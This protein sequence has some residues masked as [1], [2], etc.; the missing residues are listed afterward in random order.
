MIT[1]R[2]AP[3]YHPSLMTPPPPIPTFFVLDFETSGPFE[4]PLPVEVGVARL[5]P[6][7]NVSTVVNSFV[8]LPEGETLS[9]FTM[10]ITG[11]RPNDLVGA[12]DLATALAPLDE[13]LRGIS[14][15]M[16]AAHHAPFDAPIF[17]RNIRCCPRAHATPF[18]CTVL[19]GRAVVPGLPSYKLDRLAE[20]VGL[21][22]P[23]KR[24]RAI[25][26]AELTAH[27][28]HRLRSRAAANGS[29]ITQPP[30]FPRVSLLPPPFSA[31]DLVP[32]LF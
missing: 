14:Y 27:M 15:P 16:L 26:D 28:L 4:H 3:C 18:V 1:A 24:H 31:E 17:W 21:D 32:P 7:G 5:D 6:D 22:V 13:A 25:V 8:A 23:E 30:L 2:D 11:I 10:Q 29:A 20:A 19:L 12:P 9:P